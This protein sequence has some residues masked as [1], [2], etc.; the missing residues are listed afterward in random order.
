MINVF[1]G[2]SD[3]VVTLLRGAVGAVHDPDYLQHHGLC[4]NTTVWLRS[5]DRGY[6]HY[7]D[8]FK[9]FRCLCTL[10]PEF[11]GEVCYPV[12]CPNGGDPQWAFGY[13]DNLYT[14]PYGEFR[15]RLADFV[16]EQ[17]DQELKRRAEL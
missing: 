12:P 7:S 16:A 4:H 1:N 2:H 17:C 8:V 3:N 11:S 5:V 9:L 6:G 10:W 15:L 13:N 14:G